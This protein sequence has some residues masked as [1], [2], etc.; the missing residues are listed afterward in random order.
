MRDQHIRMTVLGLILGWT[1]GGCVDNDKSLVI[2]GVAPLTDDGEMPAP[3]P[4]EWLS[5]GALDVCHPYF[6][7]TPVYS[8]NMQINNYIQGNCN[9]TSNALECMG[10][11]VS[12]VEVDYRWLSGSPGLDLGDSGHTIYL[13]ARIEP[14]SGCDSPGVSMTRISHVITQAIG[15]QFATLGAAAEDLVLGVEL[16]AHGTTAGGMDIDSNEF[17]F[18]LR[19]TC[20]GLSAR[21]CVEKPAA[22]GTYACGDVESY[23]AA[24]EPGQDLD[25]L[26]CE[27]GFAAYQWDGAAWVVP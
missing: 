18:P 5:A 12:E 4:S 25:R 24:W 2:A 3:N 10:V 11:T 23:Y 26:P 8:V 7:G 15:A 19:L 13:S 27:D 20:G 17:L 16:Q 9:L 21:C 1:L 14:A 22:S 6:G